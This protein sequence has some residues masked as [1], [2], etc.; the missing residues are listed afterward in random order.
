MCLLC[1]RHTQ[2]HMVNLRQSQRTVTLRGDERTLI[3]KL[4]VRSFRTQRKPVHDAT[5][6]PATFSAY[7]IAVHSMCEAVCVSAAC[8]SAT[9]RCRARL[10][11]QP[12]DAHLAKRHRS[13]IGLKLP[14]RSL[15][16]S[17]A[18]NGGWPRP[19]GSLDCSLPRG[20]RKFIAAKHG[21]V[22]RSNGTEA[23]AD[24]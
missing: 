19:H 12:S 15:A 14:C 9:A 3:R 2:A 20:V 13:V 23:A 18:R 21:R 10:H 5:T 11:S 16:S 7:G 17:C 1:N 6:P 24:H 4:R 22:A 8:T